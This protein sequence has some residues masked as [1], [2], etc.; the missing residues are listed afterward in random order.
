M[1]TIVIAT[2]LAFSVSSVSAAEQ[3][4]LNDDGVCVVESEKLKEEKVTEKTPKVFKNSNIKRKLKDGTVQEF[5]GNKYKIVPRTQTR[6]KKVVKKKEVRPVIVNEK[7]KKNNITLLVGYAPED[8]LE[9]TG[10]NEYTH[11]FDVFLGLQ[12]T[13][14]ILELSEDMDLSVTGQVQTNESIFGGIGVS[15]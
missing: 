13:R 2:V 12:Y 10:P 8:D 4:Q 15:F 14:D 1:K 5:D 6:Y 7:S 11:E 9:K 3:C